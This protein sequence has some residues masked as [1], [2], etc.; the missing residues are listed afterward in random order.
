MSNEIYR[1]VTS[2]AVFCEIWEGDGDGSSGG[3]G[4]SGGGGIGSGGLGRC[5]NGGE[6]GPLK[7][8]VRTCFREN[9]QDT[10][11]EWRRR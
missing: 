2:T 3:S 8:H 4:D 11:I 1:F 6:A 7:I 9:R 5:S 10:M